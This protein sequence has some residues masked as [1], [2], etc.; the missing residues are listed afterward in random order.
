MLEV[1]RWGYRN[2]ER[3]VSNVQTKVKVNTKATN[4]SRIWESCPIN[5]YTGKKSFLVH[6]KHHILYPKITRFVSNDYRLRGG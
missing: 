4:T 2:G 1:G 6:Q 5:T 3:N